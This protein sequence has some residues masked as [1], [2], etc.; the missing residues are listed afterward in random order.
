MKL[1]SQGKFVL[2][3]ATC[4]LSLGLG[5]NHASAESL[6][7]DFGQT[8]VAAPYLTTDPGHALSTISGSD[9]AWNTIKTSAANNSLL[10]GDGSSASGITLTLGQEAT[11]GNN[12]ISYSTAIANLNLAGTGG[13]VAGQQKLL[14]TGSIYGDDNASTA[15]GRDGFFGSGSG[16]SGNAIGLRVDGLAAGNYLIYVMARNVNSD[17]TSVPMNIFASAGALAGTFDFSALTGATEANTGFT[18]ASYV[19]QYTTFQAGENY[20]GLNVTVGSGD[21]LFVAVD[22]A[23]AGETRGFLNMLEI[24]TAPVP[25]PSTGAMFGAGMLALAWAFRKRQ[26]VS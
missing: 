26:F 14:T 1:T 24:T 13:A 3:T 2:K 20:I 19:D 4:L 17:A 6:L 23:S 12:I 7:F 5:L 10:Y 25:E 15:V 8:N 18:S 22:G 11:A 9:T 16:T 21:S